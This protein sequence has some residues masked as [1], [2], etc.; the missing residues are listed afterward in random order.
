MVCTK[1]LYN[2]IDFGLLNIK[3]IDL[4]KKLK[5]KT[6]K[7]LLHKNKKKLGRSIEERLKEIE[8]REEFGHWEWDLVI[9]SKTGADEVLITV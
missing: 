3:N 4:P 9:G 2:Y 8:L 1:T 6:K 5:R 7:R